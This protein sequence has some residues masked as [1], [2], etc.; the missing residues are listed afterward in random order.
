MVGKAT[1]SVIRD[2]EVYPLADFLNRT[3]MGVKAYRRARREGL[4]AH[5]EGRRTYIVGRS[6]REYL[7]RKSATS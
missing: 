3:G 1:G 5:D 4:A 2:D 7:E 6:W